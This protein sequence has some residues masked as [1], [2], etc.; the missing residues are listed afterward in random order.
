MST[1]TEN[2]LLSESEFTPYSQIKAEHILPAMKEAVKQAEEI[3]EKTVK[4]LDS[5]EELLFSNTLMPFIEM[6]EILDK[7]WSPVENL[8]S[9]MGTKDIRE[10]AEEARPLMIDFYN[11]YAMDE[12]VYKLVKKYAQ[13]DEAKSLDY[14]RKRYLEITIR[15]FILS[16]AELDEKQKTRFKELNLEGAE[17]S[18]KFSNNVTDSKFEL[19]ITDEKDLS[20]LPDDFIE[21]AKLKADEIRKELANGGVSVAHDTKGEKL[22]EIPEK[23]WAVNLDYP[24]FGPFMKFADNGALRK[25]I[26]FQYLNRATA[27]GKDNKDL[28]KKIFDI[29]TE[30]SKTLGYKNYAEVSLATK[31]AEKPEKVKG[32]LEKLATKVQALAKTEYAALVKFQKEIG[33]KNMENNPDKVCLWD[34]DY[35]SE[36]LRK[37]EYAFDTNLLKQYFELENCIQGMF[38]IANKVLHVNFEKAKNSE[39]WHEDVRFYEIKDN[40]GHKIGNFYLDLH[41]RDIKRQGAWMM[42][43]IQGAEKIDGGYRHPQ[44][45]CSCNLTKASPGNA[46]LLNHI[47][48]VTLFHE[49]GHALHHL[50][51]EAKLAPMAGTNV[52]WDFVELPSQLYENWAWEKDSLQKFAKHYETGEV[53]PDDLVDKLNRSRVFNEG[54]AC[55]RQLEFSLFDLTIYM[56]EELKDYAEVLNTFK[57]ITDKHGIFELLEGTNFPTSFEHIFAGGYSAGYYS[58]KWAEVL[59]ADVFSRF[60]EEGIL[61]PKVGRE[62]RDKI[63]AKGDTEPPAKLFEDFMGRAPSEQALL[64]RMGLPA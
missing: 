48:L 53:I 23:A 61:D 38:D 36:K 37:Q 46:T 63:L 56:K 18:Q 47:E 44:A 14:E 39:L 54:L 31:M 33:Y 59:E 3:L 17:L 10:A 8:L 43:L 4:N 57:E 41:P 55:V 50:L 1:I 35:L 7:V 21:A 11:R 58:Y 2:P 45:I 20:G 49:F 13:T 19:I 62:Y 42:P 52:E 25:Q 5:K 64:E 27:K 9:L 51:T 12:R 32:F 28:I 22:K 29:K 40:T 6:E 16:G 30:K 15:D 26:Y 34:K 24:S 60:K